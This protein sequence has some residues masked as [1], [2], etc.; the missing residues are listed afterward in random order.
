MHCM[1]RMATSLTICI[2]VLL[3]CTLLC[4]FLLGRT[5]EY[6]SHMVAVHI[7][8]CNGLVDHILEHCSHMVVVRMV[9][10]PLMKD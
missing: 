8:L 1:S 2:L 3:V 9:H 5:L 6:Y 10:N 7:L 4:I